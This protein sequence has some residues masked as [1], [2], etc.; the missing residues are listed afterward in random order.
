[1]QVKLLLTAI[2]A[3][4]SVID[5]SSILLVFA[6]PGKSH[7]ILGDGFLRWLLA[8][9]HQVTYI[10][11]FPKNSMHPNL[12]VVDV[13]RNL[14]LFHENLINIKAIFEKKV[15][16]DSMDNLFHLMT[17]VGNRT[18]TN[19]NVQKIVMDSSQK[20]DAVIVEWLF[21]EVASGLSAVFDCPLIWFSTVEPHWMVTKLI[22]ENLNPAYNPDFK[23]GNIPPFTFT[24]RVQE[25]WKQIY[26]SV[27]LD[28]FFVPKE[29]EL[30]QAVFGPAVAIRGKS[31]PSFHDV[32]FNASLM[33]GNSHVS[34]GQATRLPQSYKPIGGYHIDPDVKPLPED[35]KKIFD[36]EK[37]GIIYFSMGSNLKSKDLPEKLKKDL[38]KMFGTLKYTVLWKF[39]EIL[40][41]LPRNVH[42]IKWAPQPS[43]LAHP[44]TILFVTHGGLLSTTETIHFGVP[45]IGIPVFADQ[46]NNVDRAVNK[47]FAKR[48]DLS[49]TIADDLKAAIVEITS[50]PRYAAKVKELSLIYHDRPVSPGKELVHWVEH[51]IKT[52]GAP[53]LRSPA[54]YVPW[55]QKMYL[56]L[57]ALILAGLIAIKIVLKRLFCSKTSITSEKK[58][59]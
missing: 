12:T 19:D 44:K 46:F 33:L 25:L 4:L 52:K 7:A 50:N 13:S 36:N 20:F 59:N 15:D 56:D 17:N 41:D 2:L 57:A 21:W 40:P 8:A 34:L 28:L 9:G 49:Y 48:V 23:T 5:A 11:P 38:L 1:M 53:H 3:S 31:L 24:Q 18:F 6:L 45:I 29:E 51:V 39:E 27:Y 30:Y 22:D 54:L 35:L 14:E 47:G 26:R 37:H 42:I 32:R 55:Y 10:T 58:Y 43:I 16:M